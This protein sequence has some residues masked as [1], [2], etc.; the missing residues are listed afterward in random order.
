MKT[1]ISLKA[2]VLCLGAE[3][4]MTPE[5]A[6]ELRRLRLNMS[7]Y[8]SLANDCANA[9]NCVLVIEGVPY[10]PDWDYKI[11]YK[12]SFIFTNS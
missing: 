5:L 12:S 2:I 4:R 10:D 8:Y 6:A 1:I 11:G 7:D 9:L 3:G